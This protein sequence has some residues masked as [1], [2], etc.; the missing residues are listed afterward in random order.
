MK[1]RI[2]AHQKRRFSQAF[3]GHSR[4]VVATPIYVT[5]GLAYG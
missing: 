4:P 1:T 2:L 5:A 3:N